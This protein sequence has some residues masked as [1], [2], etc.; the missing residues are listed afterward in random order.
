[1]DY[2]VCEILWLKRILEKLK[3]SVEPHMKLFFYNKATSGITNNPIQHECIKHI[4]I[5]RHF[6]KEKLESKVI[7]MLFIT[8]KQLINDVLTKSLSRPRFETLV[9][10]LGMMNIYAST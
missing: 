7:Y 6:T 9:T 5:D 3:L 8:T 1:M 4:E 10:K 2:G